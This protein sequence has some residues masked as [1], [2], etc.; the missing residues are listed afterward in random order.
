MKSITYFEYI[1]TMRA[2]ST[3]NN[4]A[5]SEMYLDPNFDIENEIKCIKEEK[6]AIILAHYYQD[7]RIQEIAD[8][9]GDSLD[10]S[11]KAASTNAQVIVFCGVRFMAEV[12]K[13]L[14]PNKI[15]LLPDQNAGC[16]LEDSCQ[17]NT[18]RKF[19]KKYPDHIVVSYINCSA[20]IKAQS[21]IIVTSS[22]A[23][24]IIR[25]I[26]IENKIL[27][28]PDRHLGR[29]LIK[30]LNRDM[31]L[32]NGSCIVHEQ[33]SEKALI[34]LKFYNPDA[35]ITAHPECHERILNHA[36][37][38]GSTR[39]MLEYV[40]SNQ[41]KTYLIAT[42]PHIIYQMK[43]LCPN[44]IFIPVPGSD[45]DC[46]CNNCPFMELNTLEKL[47]LCLLNNTPQILMSQDLIN[48][49]GKPLQRMLNMSRN[50]SIKKD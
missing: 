41:S 33:F 32:W 21:D 25:Q 6:N 17:P 37:H 9:V 26:P 29:Y 20:A 10:L 2:D 50:I 11:R 34:K 47:Y 12:A 28:A 14:N 45:G 1:I 8:F 49:A 48:A 39:S 27:W 36:D 16:S 7:D 35:K 43:K 22:N 40:Q 5:I 13:I 31:I 44:K 18:F 24:E 3:V 30:K 46:A 15:V 38:I 23:A 4:H 42:E 19:R